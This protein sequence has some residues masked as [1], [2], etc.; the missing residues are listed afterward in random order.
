VPSLIIAGGRDWIPKS[1]SMRIVI[2]IIQ[3]SFSIWPMRYRSS[4]MG[5]ALSMLG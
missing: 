1:N 4:V 2:D 5:R 3:S